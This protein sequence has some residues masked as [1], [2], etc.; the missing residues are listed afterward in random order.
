M[1]QFR[2]FVYIVI[3]TGKTNGEDSYGKNRLAGKMEG[4]L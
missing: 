3:R 1:S 4:I 2:F